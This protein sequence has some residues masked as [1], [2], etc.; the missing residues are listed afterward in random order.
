MRFQNNKL[1]KM[2]QKELQ[3]EWMQS[4]NVL[5]RVTWSDGWAAVGF[6][7]VVAL[8]VACSRTSEGLLQT[9]ENLLALAAL[10][11]LPLAIG[12]LYRPA[13]RFGVAICCTLPNVFNRWQPVRC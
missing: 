10:V 1:R 11:H 13:T 3:A 9:I 4:G 7:C 12:L 6:A 5:K 2:S 8:Y